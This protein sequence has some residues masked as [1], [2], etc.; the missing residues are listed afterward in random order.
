[1]R[2]GQ[3]GLGGPI[4]VLDCFKLENDDSISHFSFQ[5]PPDG[6]FQVGDP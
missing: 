2:V 5:R 3:V 6:S 1:M 4:P